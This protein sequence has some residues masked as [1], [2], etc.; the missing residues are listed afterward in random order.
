MREQERAGLLGAL[1][2]A[3]VVRI[4]LGAAVLLRSGTQ[5]LVAED[6]AS[7]LEPGR[8]L[9]WHGAFQTAGM[10]E[11]GR[12]PG[13]P[14]FLAA[15]SGAGWTLAALA[16]VAVSVLNVW[17]VV[18]LARALGW[19]EPGVRSAAWLMAME[20]LAVVYSVRLLAETLFC[21]F[22]LVSFERLVV[23][24]RVRTWS[25]L[26]G[27][28][29]ALSLAIF[30]RPVGYPLPLLWA[31]ALAIWGWRQ[32]PVHRPHRSLLWLKAPALLLA[33]TAPLLAAWQLRNFAV[34]G[35]GGFSSIAIRN[36][37]FYTAAV[38][39]AQAEG[40]SLAAEQSAFGY[41]DEVAYLRS[42]PEQAAWSQAARLRYMRTEGRRILAAHWAGVVRMQ[43][44]G[45]GVVMFSPGAAEALEMLRLGAGPAPA[46][47]LQEGALRAAWRILRS[48]PAR[49]AG[50]TLLELWLLALYGL[51]LRGAWRCGCRRSVLALLIGT[52]F[53]FFVLSGGIQAV[54]RFRMPVMPLVCVLAGAGLL[55]QRASV[56]VAP[57][58]SPLA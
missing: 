44:A 22:L 31:A 58:K 23:F 16:Q 43:L 10:P 52:A 11:I 33:S 57:A 30:V 9:L 54:S 55:E 20:P 13:Y 6:T 5:G 24:L 35:Y 29:L 8:N 27:S 53:C 34:S 50:M 28:G 36:T 42:H 32:P 19:K 15:T 40:R 25:A 12:T 51:A 47:V 7:Y 2:G 1:A 49:A 18:R 14:L 45:A 46:R 48:D 17:L 26:C 4:A 56:P 21:A 38:A 39:Q 3:A 37:Y 41:P